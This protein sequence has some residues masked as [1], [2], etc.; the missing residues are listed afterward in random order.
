MD[1]PQA[2]RDPAGLERDLLVLVGIIQAEVKQ[3]E[4]RAVGPVEGDLIF[5][6]CWLALRLS[7]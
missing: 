5:S 2:D 6:S 7:R 3:G 4:V 1:L